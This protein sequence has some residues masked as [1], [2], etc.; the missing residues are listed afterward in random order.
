MHTHFRKTILIALAL[1]LT[2][3]SYVNNSQ[4]LRNRTYDYTGESVVNLPAPPQTPSGLATPQFA[5]A[6]AIPP[7][8]DSYPPEAHPN[9]TPP[10]FS[11]QVPIPVLPPK[12]KATSNS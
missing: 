12:T 10:G 3:C 5:P 6:L 2:G 9:M 11:T 4:S 7:G 8:P 1:A